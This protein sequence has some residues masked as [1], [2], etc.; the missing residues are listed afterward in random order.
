MYCVCTVTCVVLSPCA[1]Q[2]S[3]S[4]SSHLYSLET[5]SDGTYPPKQ[6]SHNKWNSFD[7]TNN[8]QSQLIQ[9]QI[10]VKELTVCYQQLVKL[11]LGQMQAT[12]NFQSLH[13]SLSQMLN[14]AQLVRQKL[15][16][17]LPASG[18]PNSSPLKQQLTQTNEIITQL[19]QHVAQ[20]QNMMSQQFP[21][22]KVDHRPMGEP[23]GDL[24]YAMRDMSVSQRSQAPP[25][26]MSKLHR[27]ISSQEDL[28][29]IPYAPTT[30]VSS[31]PSP[32]PFSPSFRSATTPTMPAKPVHQIQEFK[33]GVPWQSKTKP[34]PLKQNEHFYNPGVQRSTSFG[35]QSG[36]FG[37]PGRYNSGSSG[38]RFVRSQSSDNNYYGNQSQQPPRGDHPWSSAGSENRPQG[39][40]GRG[41]NQGRPSRMSLPTTPVSSIPGDQGS[42]RPSTL[43]PKQDYQFKQFERRLSRGTP[44]EHDWIPETPT[45]SDPVWGSEWPKNEWTEQLSGEQGKKWSDFSEWQHGSAGGRGKGRP[46]GPPLS[47]WLVVRTNSPQVTTYYSICYS[48]LWSMIYS[49]HSTL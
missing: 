40:P 3:S 23:G 46:T 2:P 31:Y 1:L 12:G 19:K 8:T 7:E 49:S 47:P 25:R 34:E 39:F 17:Q 38:A 28:T 30:P 32:S 42:W 36:S 26:S 35:Q 45:N 18:V 33:P 37:G 41:W 27:I 20:S 13:K 10:M 5:P 9:N 21:P 48:L 6:P 14:Q 43:L 22:R 24:S 44:I 15:V 4:D 16:N 29:D 11:K